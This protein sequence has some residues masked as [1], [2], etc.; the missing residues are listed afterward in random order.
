MEL[1]HTL[2]DIIERPASTSEEG[3]T[4]VYRIQL[5][6]DSDIYRSHFP[7]RPITP[8]ACIIQLVQ[9]LA[10]DHFHA[11]ALQIRQITNLKF[12][13]LLEPQHHPCIDVH[14]QGNPA[15]LHATLSDGPLIF[16]RLTCAF[17]S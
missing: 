4:V 6:P 13:A 15:Q 14:L 3:A 9:E 17:S 11:P 1:R 2:Y 7:G 16:A 8:G 5:H 12:L 10:Q